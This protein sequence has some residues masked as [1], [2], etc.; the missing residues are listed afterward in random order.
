MPPIRRRHLPLHAVLLAAGLATGCVHGP[1]V[2]AAPDGDTAIQPP[3][4]GCIQWIG[5]PHAGGIAMGSAVVLSPHHLLTCAHVWAT[6]EPWWDE[7]LQQARETLLF[8]ASGDGDVT[9]RRRRLRLCASGMD[10]RTQRATP[11]LD[12][13]ALLEADEPLW[14][15]AAAAPVLWDAREPAWRVPSGSELRVYGYAHRFFAG[16]MP[17]GPAPADGAPL[18]GGWRRLAEFVR[19]GPYCIAGTAAA[20]P[21]APRLDCTSD[22][23]PPEGHSGGGVFVVD[24]A[25]GAL[26]L[27]GLFHSHRRLVAGE[28]VEASAGGRAARGAPRE[29]SAVAALQYAPI[30]PAAFTIALLQDVARARREAAALPER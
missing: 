30:A 29:A 19:N 9:L 8:E 12:D 10:T 11:T 28:P 5:L 1:L 22:L 26:R 18:A 15:E 21:R 13:W 2:H 6:A 25:S 24:E 3:P 20:D 17:D 16:P 4:P 27:V 14:P 23:A 7:R